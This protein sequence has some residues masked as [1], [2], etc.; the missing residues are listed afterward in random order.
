MKPLSGEQLLA[1]LDA[2]EADRA[3]REHAWAGDAPDKV[4]QAVCAFAN[5]LPGHGLPGVAFIGANDDGS[6]SG[7]PIDDR[8]LLTLADIKTDGRIVPPPSLT[9]ERRVL[10]GSPMAVVTVWPADSPPVRFDGRIWIR[11]GPRRD[12]ATAQ[13]ERVLNE[14]RRTRDS[15]FESHPVPRAT[16]S[17]LNRTAFENDYLPAAVARDVLEA[18]ERSYEQ[19]LAA[20][21]MV[22]TA[23]DPVPTVLGLLVVGVSPRD[24]LPGSYIQFLR[25]AGRELADPVVDAAEIDGNIGPMLRELDAKLR[26]H[27]TT[28]VDF[29]GLAVERR[30][31]PYPLTA[32]QQLTRNAVMHRNYEGTNT[33]VHVYWFDDRIEISLVTPTTATRSSRRP[34]KCSGWRRASVPASRSR[35]ASCA[36]TAIQRLASRWSRTSWVSSSLREWLRRTSRDRAGTHVLQQQRR[37]RQDVAGAAPCLDVQ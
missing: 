5:D 19:R 20:C 1:L 10:K 27:L 17:D 32:L 25:I 6:A 4:R 34:S 22:A 16:L 26:A 31:S 36:G 12:R 3:E 37:C 30:I 23:E 29:A 28:R 14:R 33:P 9:V 15:H 8:L 35:R 11:T 21:G 18:N 24:W 2:P 7:V 13:D